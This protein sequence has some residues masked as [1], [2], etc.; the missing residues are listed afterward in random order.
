MT[1]PV[2]RAALAGA[3]ILAIAA[4][5]DA[6]SLTPE[7]NAAAAVR[8]DES[9]PE[10]APAADPAASEAFASLVEDY[11]AFQRE[12]SLS[13]RARDGDLDAM[14]RWPDV[15]AEHQA[16][17]TAQEA[18][19]LERLETIDRDGLDR[20]DRVSYDVLDYSLRFSVELAPFD[21]ARTPFLND[22]GF[23]TAPTYAAAST[24]PRNAEQ[25]EAWIAR[26]RNLPDYFQANID[27]MNRGLQDGF[28]QPRLIAELAASQ[29]EALADADTLSG[30][31]I[32]PVDALPAGMPQAERDRLRAETEAAIAEAALPAYENL[33]AYFRDTYIPQTRESLGI[34][35]VP[36]G[37]EYYQ[38]LVR[39]HT[40]LDTSPEEVHQRGL[41][42][43]A[44][45]REEMDAV[46]A[47]TGFEGTFAEFLHFLRTD[48]QFYAETPEELLMHAAWIAK[49][50]DDQ[51]PRFFGHLPRL[52]YGV[53]PVPDTM[54][55]TYTTG[56]YWGGDLENGVAGGYMVNT[57]DLSQRPLYTLPALTVHEA[58]PGHHHQISIAAELEDVPDFRRNTYI[59]AFGEGWGLYTENL[60]IDMGL[61]T[62]PYEDFGRLTYEM[63]RACRLV[64]DTGIHYMG[65]T[66]EQAEA[67]F[68]ENSALAPHNIRTEVQRYISWPGQALAYKSGELLMRDLRRQAEERL[69]AGFDIRE[70]HDVLLRD[71]AMPLSALE[72]KMLAW[73]EDE[74]AALEGE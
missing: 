2:V 72:E 43:V 59:T 6:G 33:L 27:W 52:P 23:F 29:I 64:V 44:R 24:R 3:S 20:N 42:E 26:L 31:L 69:G 38:T 39:Y 61:Y 74:A 51:M 54:A 73:I 22:S 30:I 66:R 10:A 57:Y 45:I 25:G 53:R 55:P 14:S 34:S 21:T 68:L 60:A 70:F 40:T 63:W 18:A 7:A 41:A 62:T 67:C 15:S 46:I 19:F 28:T 48:P 58:V 1:H 71:G 47:E 37:R 36:Q 49:R 65:W 16:E 12:N 17:E 4:C 35:D 56:R 8:Q 5:N 9:T 13:R 50:A 11:E 32:A